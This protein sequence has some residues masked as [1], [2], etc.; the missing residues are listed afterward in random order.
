MLRDLG[1]PIAVAAY[2]LVRLD[3]LITKN[4]AAL[5]AVLA[6]VEKLVAGLRAADGS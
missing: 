3:K 4:T 1:F 5:A 6:V 2:L